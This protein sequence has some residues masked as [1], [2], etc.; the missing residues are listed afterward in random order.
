[1]V[2]YVV[3]TNPAPVAV[4]YRS[5]QHWYQRRAELLPVGTTQALVLALLV[6]IQMVQSSATFPDSV[7]RQVLWLHEH[8]LKK[9]LNP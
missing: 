9:R 1:M 3:T 8:V 6:A 2:R 7:I 5:P 4:V